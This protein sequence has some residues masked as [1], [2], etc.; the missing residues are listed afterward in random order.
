MPRKKGVR[1]NTREGDSRLQAAID[2]WRPDRP[3]QLLV[4]HGEP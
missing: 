2:A 1:V 4:M 3:R